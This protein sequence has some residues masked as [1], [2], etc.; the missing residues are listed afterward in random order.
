MLVKQFISQKCIGYSN[1]FRRTHYEHIVELQDGKVV[2]VWSTDIS[3]Q[4]TMTIEGQLS[5]SHP[6]V[7]RAIT[8]A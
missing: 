6:L 7:E 1:D 8:T 4:D 3:T 5:E 2:T